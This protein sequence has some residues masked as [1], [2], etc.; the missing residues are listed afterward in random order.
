[1]IKQFTHKIVTVS[2]IA[3]AFIALIFV[4]S[5]Y[6]Y[7][8]SGAGLEPESW[9]YNKEE[10]E[11][12]L[13][14]GSNTLLGYPS[15][16][17]GAGAF[18]KGI[19]VSEFQGTI[20]WE[21]VKAAG[22]DYAIL[23]ISFGYGNGYDSQFQR[24]ASECERLGIPY[25]VYSYSYCEWVD[26]NRKEAENV[27][28]LLKG[29]HPTYPVYIDLE[30]TTTLN[31]V[32]KGFNLN[33]GAKKFCDVIEAAGYK[34]GIY[35]NLSWFNNYLTSDSLDSYEKW[36]AQWYDICQY[37][38]PFG[39][40]QCT[41]A[42]SVDGISGSVD[43]DYDYVETRHTHTLV[44]TAAQDATCTEE[45]NTE[46]YTCSKCNYYFQDAEGSIRIQKDSWVI[47]AKGHKLVKK[48]CLPAS[49][50]KEGYLEHYTCSECESCYS[51]AEGKQIITNI[52][53]PRI[54]SIDLDNDC[55][56][57]DGK[58]KEPKVKALDAKGAILKGGIDYDISYEN[59]IQVGTA[60]ATI[61]FKGNYFGTAV[62]EYIIVTGYTIK[63]NIVGFSGTGLR[64]DLVCP[65]GTTKRAITTSYRFN[66]LEPGIYT[67]KI[68]ADGDYVG[69][70]LTIDVDGEE[71]KDI[72]LCQI[73]DTDCDG[74]ITASDVTL[75]ARQ[76]AHINNEQ[77]E[78][79]LNLFD[80]DNDRTIK[81]ADA[82]RLARY[83]ALI[84][85]SL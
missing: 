19:D 21:K 45:G 22:I 43:L 40:W 29:Y 55:Y 5:L 85:S 15:T 48:E 63:G 18:R 41:S 16:P 31:A 73:G 42:Y 53:I 83:V 8:H 27:L 68:S 60:T 12:R 44:K 32:K 57:A 49:C 80:V 36:V 46:Y 51:D 17:S 58:A 75:I 35:A 30:D 64:I 50:S 82:T 70:E 14:L 2:I 1:M 78:Y 10:S 52:I 65:D 26:E 62:R 81:I 79:R 59:N 3:L 71:S 77:D 72:E 9:K 13:L 6:S 47:P 69:R 67:L 84:T 33:E 7:A 28:G 20:N 61:T 54:T 37:T 74:L 24:N 56:I 23:R 4:S 34:A 76:V 66:N 38:K 25:G 39:M 11:P